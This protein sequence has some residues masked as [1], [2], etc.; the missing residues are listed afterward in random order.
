[1]WNDFNYHSKNGIFLFNRNYMEY[2]SDRFQD[3]S[4]MFY[5]NKKLVA[6]MPAHSLDG[7]LI[8]HNGLT[9]GGLIYNHKMNTQTIIDIFS[10]LINYSRDNGFKKIYYKAI[11]HIYHTYPAEED[12]Y[13]LKINNFNLIRRD[14][15]SAIYLNEKIPF[16]RGRRRNLE[17]ARNNGIKVKQSNLFKDFMLIAQ[18]NTQNKYKTNTVHT[19]EEMELLASKFPEN[20]KLFLAERGEEILAGV[21]MYES[22]NV[23]HGQYH[24]STDEGLKNRASDVILDFLINDYYKDKKYFDLGISTENDGKF[25]NTGLI[26]F[27]ERFGARAIVHDF[28]ELNIE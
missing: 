24:S 19:G 21:I 5:D 8:S 1:M 11:P 6:I 4:L 15:S 14:I 9:F 26:N 7:N 16:S 28:Y 17:N 25:L 23:A 27:K 3:H 2:H 22:Q 13:A 10:E 12:L 18:E 20:I